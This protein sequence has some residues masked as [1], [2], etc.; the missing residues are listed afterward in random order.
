MKNVL[1]NP[2]SPHKFLPTPVYCTLYKKKLNGLTRPS[3]SLPPAWNVGEYSVVDNGVE[4]DAG[5][6]QPVCPPILHHHLL[7][8]TGILLFRN[9]NKKDEQNKVKIVGLSTEI[10]YHVDVLM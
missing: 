1:M 4:D 3:T 5:L 7:S 6:L 10:R 9:E 2:P 8:S